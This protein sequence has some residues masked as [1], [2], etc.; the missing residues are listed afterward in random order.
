MPRCANAQ[1]SPTGSAHASEAYAR[2]AGCLQNRKHAGARRN[3][4]IAAETFFLLLNLDRLEVV[5]LVGDSLVSHSVFSDS[6]LSQS[7]CS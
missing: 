5:Y 3:S 4:K 2:R 1:R 7:C 6:V